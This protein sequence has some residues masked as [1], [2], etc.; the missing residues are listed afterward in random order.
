[1]EP[2]NTNQALA[3]WIGCGEDY[4]NHPSTTRG[5]TFFLLILSLLTSVPWRH[6]HLSSGREIVTSTLVWATLSSTPT[7]KSNS[8]LF[9]CRWSATTTMPSASSMIFRSSS[10]PT[11]L[12]SRE[13]EPCWKTLPHLQRAL[14]EAFQVVVNVQKIA[15]RFSFFP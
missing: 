14:Q 9:V 8:C 10:F 4:S 6:C 2:I 13:P 3:P 5:P 7:I 15:L 1:M 12:G 11:L